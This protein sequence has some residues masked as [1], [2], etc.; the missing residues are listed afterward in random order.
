[1]NKLIPTNLFTLKLLPL[2]PLP[3]VADEIKA[4]GFDYATPEFIMLYSI[5]HCT[6]AVQQKCENPGVN[7]LNPDDSFH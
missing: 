5:Q 4:K 3:K 2:Y 1:M 7:K 6:L